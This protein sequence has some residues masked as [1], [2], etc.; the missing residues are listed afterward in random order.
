MNAQRL[1]LDE[2]R[3]RGVE[4][5]LRELGPVGMVRFLQQFDPGEGD[6]TRD[7]DRWLPQGDVRTLGAMVRQRLSMSG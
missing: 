1:T 2:I 7:R 3:R 5:L 6:Y 4:A